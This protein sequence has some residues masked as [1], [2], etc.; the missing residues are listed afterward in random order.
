MYVLSNYGFD[1]RFTS[2]TQ[3]KLLFCKIILN[4]QKHERDLIVWSKA[5]VIEE[6]CHILNDAEG[7]YYTDLS[8][9]TVAYLFVNNPT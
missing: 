8:S 6:N 5:N 1:F 9:E 3:L 4:A 7:F 2:L